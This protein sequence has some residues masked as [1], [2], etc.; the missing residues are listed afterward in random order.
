MQ[1]TLPESDDRTFW[2]AWMSAFHFQALAIADELG[3]LTRFQ[4][5][6]MAAKAVAGQLGLPIRPVEQLIAVLAGLGLLVEEGGYFALTGKARAYLLP[7]SP[8]YWGPALSYFRQITVNF[9][10]MRGEFQKPDAAADAGQDAP[11]PGDEETRFTRAMHSFS[12][13]AAAAIAQSNTFDRV[14]RLLDVGGGSG[15]YCIALALRYPDKHFTVGDLPEVLPATREFIA[16]YGAQE[17][18]DVL[19]FDMLAPAWPGSFDAHFFSNVFHDFDDEMCRQLAASS[20]A[21]LPPG[22]RIFV[23]EVL[24]NDAKDGP[25]T[26]ATFALAMTYFNRRGGQYTAAEIAGFLAAAG[27]KNITTAP[28]FGYYSLTSGTKP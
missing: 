27:F 23:H 20:Y 9:D 26:P 24:M 4:H 21:A 16:D 14:Q 10:R 8:F 22:G 18:V 5:R 25:L 19:A 2:D 13:A 12:F 17:Q 3:I 11:A 28:T 1:L 7:D 6:P 15:S